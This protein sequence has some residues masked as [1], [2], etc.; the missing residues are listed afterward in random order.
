VAKREPITGS[1]NVQLSIKAVERG[2]DTFL[3]R[4][5]AQSKLK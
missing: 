2:H 5:L 3:E 1:R 4:R